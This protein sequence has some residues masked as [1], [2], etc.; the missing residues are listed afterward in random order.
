MDFDEKHAKHVAMLARRL[1]GD[2]QKEHQFDLRMELLLYLAACC[3]KS[4]ILL[5]LVATIS[6]LCT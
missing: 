3:T 6:M 5:I 4:V 1:F 2:L